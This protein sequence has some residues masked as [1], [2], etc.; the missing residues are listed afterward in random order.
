MNYPNLYIQSY[1]KLYIILLK[2]NLNTIYPRQYYHILH[3]TNFN[4]HKKWLKNDSIFINTNCLTNYQSNWKS[5]IYLYKCKNTQFI[6]YIQL[7]TL[8]HNVNRNAVYICSQPSFN[9]LQIRIYN[10]WFKLSFF[11]YTHKSLKHLLFIQT[12][13]HTNFYSSFSQLNSKLLSTTL[14]T[15]KLNL[16]HNVKFL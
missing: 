13:M 2:Y 16:L 7:T 12:F 8:N 3:S 10:L 15:S 6:K 14:L 9:S 1:Y 4:L 5:T 11:S